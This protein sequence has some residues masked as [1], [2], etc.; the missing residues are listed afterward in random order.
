[1]KIIIAGGSGHLGTLLTRHFRENGHRVIILS[2]KPY[3]TDT[4]LWDGRNPGSWEEELS[5]SDIVI[6]LA[7]RSVDCRYNQENRRQMMDSRLYSTRAIGQAIRKVERP[8]ALWLQMSTATIYAHTHGHANDEETGILGGAEIDA[9]DH[10]RFSVDLARD[11]EAEARMWCRDETRLVL[12]RSAMVM[13]S[14]PGTV[15]PILMTLA[16]RGLGGRMGTGRQYLSWFHEQDFIRAVDCLIEDSSLHGPVNLAAPNPIDNDSFMRCLRRAMGIGFG[17]PAP[18]WL[19]EIGALFMRTETELL[20][21]SRKVVPGKLRAH[22]F[23]FDYPYWQDAVLELV[24]RSR[25]A[26]D[27]QRRD[28]LD[29]SVTIH[30]G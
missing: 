10:W 1:M 20:L 16:G 26:R 19:L 12:M 5:Y 28:L 9:P 27:N 4:V 24:R 3:H 2:R 7:G 25:R 23:D 8:P 17:L 18:K 30:Q 22:G 14:H 21:K 15:L 6:N 29:R 11:W 13:S